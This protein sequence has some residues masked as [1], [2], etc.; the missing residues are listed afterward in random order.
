MMSSETE[1]MQERFRAIFDKEVSVEY[2]NSNIWMTFD[3]QG[4][5]DILPGSELLFDPH[6]NYNIDDPEYQ[7][8]FDSLPETGERIKI[9][10]SPE[11]LGQQKIFAAR[12]IGRATSKYL[13]LVKLSP[14]MVD[15][16]GWIFLLGDSLCAEK[17]PEFDNV[18]TSYKVFD[19]FQQL[20]DHRFSGVM[21]FL[22][23][24]TILEVP[25]IFNKDCVAKL[26]HAEEFLKVNFNESNPEWSIF[27]SVIYDNLSRVEK[28]DRLVKFFSIFDT[29]LQEFKVSCSI[30]YEKYNLNLLKKELDESF[31]SLNEKIRN[32]V[33]NVKGE[34]ILIVSMAF[35]LSQFD[36][37]WGGGTAKNII[38]G[39]SLILASVIYSYLIWND[40]ES[41]EKLREIVDAE[42]ERL[43]EIS[44]EEKYETEKSRSIKK[45]A[46]CLSDRIKYH[47]CFL[48]FCLISIWLPIIILIIA[49]IVV[50]KP[51]EPEVKQ[52]IIAMARHVIS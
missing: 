24:K 42:K 13:Q 28:A 22:C 46:D 16:S 17:P 39:V 34:L 2:D 35:A 32:S 31:I 48:T 5:R 21:A 40:K 1:M 43:G 44:V 36:F 45:N 25:S 29:I 37:M 10:T 11:I 47:N 51:M 30:H 6:N 15:L 50:G 27:K 19:K 14:G 26:D 7:L 20:S 4:V 9:L 33:D 8:P 52:E 23:G 3:Y 41:L 12:D 49:L 18:D 38:I